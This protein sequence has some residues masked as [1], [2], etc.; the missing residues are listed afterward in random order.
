MT[1]KQSRRSAD[2]RSD[3]PPLRMTR[4]IAAGA[5]VVAA[6]VMRSIQVAVVS[7]AAASG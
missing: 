2:N 3:V 1:V 4:R 5:V 7:T 6:L